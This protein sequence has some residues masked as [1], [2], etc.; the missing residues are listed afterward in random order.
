[1]GKQAGTRTVVGIALASA[2]L[3]AGC[4]TG[5]PTARR[6]D[7]VATSASADATATAIDRLK[8]ATAF[9]DRVSFTARVVIAEGQILT[10]SRTNN[11]TRRA[12]TTLTSAEQV[13]EVR[14]IDDDVYMLART[15]PGASRGWMVL[16]PAKIPAGF[17]MSFDRGENDPGGSARLI[18][19]ITSARVSGTEV[20]GTIDI[21]KVGTGNGISYRPNPGTFPE[22]MRSQEFRATLD[23]QGRLAE[24]S[25]PGSQGLPAG[26]LS[27]GDFGAAVT[28]SPPRG[29]VPAPESLYPQ[30]GFS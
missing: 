1:M 3:A 22:S 23:S 15:L 26:S 27:Y 19:A 12:V 25:I 10:E 13:I 30:L 7:P 18:N 4:S 28:V 11:V 8:A 14:M 20:S 6:P 24:F 21:V 17:A 2:A 16:D 29:A 5:E 9:V